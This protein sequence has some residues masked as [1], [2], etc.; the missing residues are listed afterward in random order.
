MSLAEREEQLTDLLEG[1]LQGTD[2][3]DL[4]EHLGTCAECRQAW[5][6]LQQ[7]DRHLATLRGEPGPD[8][9]PEVMR[10]LPKAAP[11]QPG[12]LPRFPVLPFLA[13]VTAVAALVAVFLARSP[14]IPTRDAG[15]VRPSPSTASASLPV[16]PGSPAHPLV[17]AGTPAL[18]SGGAMSESP[19]LI[20]LPAA[21]GTV[22][23]G[24]GTVWHPRA[25]GAGGGTLEM[26]AVLCDLVP[27][28]DEPFEI[29][30][31]SCRVTVLGTMFGVRA[32]PGRTQVALFQG[33]L[34]VQSGS[35]PAR[36]LSPGDGVTIEE[37]QETFAPI[38]SGDL[39]TWRLLATS[40]GLRLPSLPAVPS[41]S[42]PP[43]A[44]APEAPARSAAT[45]AVSL[46]GAAGSSA[47]V[48]D[49]PE[50]P[51]DPG[52]ATSSHRTPKELLRTIPPG[53][54]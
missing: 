33:K 12:P 30:C 35:A 11:G 54:R 43:P 31:G 46:P 17:V 48:A 15:H 53:P 7:G 36:I 20:H 45:P 4:L 24:Q 44:S 13:T 37:N 49:S 39:A 19:R 21:R 38:A 23:L 28:P 10:R 47:V 40:A 26:G 16:I 50:P 2:K 8:L 14:R 52:V 41:T 42:G 1:T 18:A 29:R 34:A 32:R 9:V 25:T 6:E 5:E 22:V 3:A 51:T 27:R